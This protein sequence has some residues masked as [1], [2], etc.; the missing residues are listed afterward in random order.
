MTFRST[1]SSKTNRWVRRALLVSLLLPIAQV[2]YVQGQ[3]FR[4]TIVGQVTDHQKAAVVGA[5]VRAIRG[6][7][8]LV[9]EVKT[10]SEGYYSIPYLLPGAYTIEISAAGF[11]TLK[12]E[13]IV[14][15]VADKLNISASLTVGGVSEAVTVLGGQDLIHTETASRGMN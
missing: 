15:Q 14:V 8:N 5:V 9:T 6:D 13:N 11:A 12:R 1:A 7:T 10:N 3:D 2:G 4:A